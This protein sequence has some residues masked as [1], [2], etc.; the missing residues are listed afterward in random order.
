MHPNDLPLVNSPMSELNPYSQ[1]FADVLFNAFP[2]WKQYRHNELPEI[3]SADVRGS[4]IVRVPC[5]SLSHWPALDNWLLIDTA[6]HEVTIT[7][8]R[9]HAHFDNW[10]DLAETEEFNKATNFLQ[11]LISEDIWIAVAMSINHEWCGST[12]IYK[13][14]NATNLAEFTKQV[15]IHCDREIASGMLSALSGIY[16]RSWQGTYDRPLSRL[17]EGT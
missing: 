11:S 13:E 1:N 4:L 5:P 14:F 7:W 10:S 2:D 8:D 3:F 16:V 15:T 12:H 17:E 9:Y 6:D